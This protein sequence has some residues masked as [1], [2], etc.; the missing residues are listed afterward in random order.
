VDD[1]AVELVKWAFTLDPSSVSVV[2]LLL[3]FVIGSIF[4]LHKEAIVLGSTWKAELALKQELK[5]ALA[6]ATTAL[7]KRTDEYHAAEVKIAELQKDR[8]YAWQRPNSAH[9][10]SSQTRRRKPQ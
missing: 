8:E 9:S 5:D 4:A 1:G 2:G 6:L 7:D 3:A 10:T